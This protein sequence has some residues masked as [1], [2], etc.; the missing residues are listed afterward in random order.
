MNSPASTVNQGQSPVLLGTSTVSSQANSQG[1]AASTSMNSSSGNSGIL[2]GTGAST[3]G[4]LAASSNQGIL[5]NSALAAQTTP[6]AA[7]PRDAG[8][9]VL[10]PGLPL[11]Q[12]HGG[13]TP[14]QVRSSANMNAA[15]LNTTSAENRTESGSAVRGTPNSMLQNQGVEGQLATGRITEKTLLDLRNLTKESVFQNVPAESSA[16]S[17]AQSSA[18]TLLKRF[19]GSGGDPAQNLWLEKGER[20]REVAYTRQVGEANAGNLQA[21]LTES[22]AASSSGKLPFLTSPQNN[23]AQNGGQGDF[24]L[25]N[26]AAGG[27]QAFLGREGDKRQSS[28]THA[29]VVGGLATVGLGGLLLF[30]PESHAGGLMAGIGC[31][32]A[33]GTLVLRRF[34]RRP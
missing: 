28:G 10:E 21:S 11:Q 7:L 2:Q 15:P 32:V 9:P 4:A 6:N 34:A 22:E 8:K 20:G 12:G 1:L 5:N 3:S 24:R 31:I 27:F 19:L 29:L 33:L 25:A 30:T 16:S 23:L 18:E 13:S 26:G 17:T 14:E